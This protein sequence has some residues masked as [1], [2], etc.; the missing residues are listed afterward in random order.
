MNVTCFR[1][2]QPLAVL[3]LLLA[4][5]GAQAMSGMDMP[6]GGHAKATPSL[7]KSIGEPINSSEAGRDVVRILEGL[8][9]A[10]VVIKHK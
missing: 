4:P 7:S 5:T 6:A 10:A 9:P 2:T 3:A 1:L 8:E